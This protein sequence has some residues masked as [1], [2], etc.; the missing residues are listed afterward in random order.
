MVI[1]AVFMMDA[2]TARPDEAT[3]LREYQCRCIQSAE[4][5]ID[6]MYSTFRTDDYFQTWYVSS[7]IE[8]CNDKDTF[9]IRF[10]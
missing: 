6:L 7:A 1:H 4:D 10:N 3:F 8:L 2:K 5:A 9:F